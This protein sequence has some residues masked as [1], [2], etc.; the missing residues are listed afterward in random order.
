MSF[1]II[2]NF[3][4]L[5][6]SIFMVLSGMLK[7][8]KKIL[9]VQTIQITLFIISNLVLGGI[10]G[11]IV[12]VISLVRNVLAYKDKLDLPGG[13]IEYGEST[14]DT[15]KREFEE[16]VGLKIEDYK[17]KTVVTNYV[18]WNLDETHLEDLQHIAIIYDVI[19]NKSSFDKIKKDADG[20]DSLGAEWYDVDSLNID[21]LSP[22]AKIIKN[23][24]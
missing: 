16:E 7:S 19:L 1:I 14:D 2:G 6:A 8:K 9:F 22:I 24:Q 23:S 21:D 18:V 17:L 12:N 15:L 3:F 13:G 4:A 5:M 20:L 11:A 10:T